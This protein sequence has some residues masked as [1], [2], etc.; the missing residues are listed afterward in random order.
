MSLRPP[1]RRFARSSGRNGPGI[2]SRLGCAAAAPSRRGVRR[3][4]YFVVL[5]SVGIVFA[6]A[7]RSRA[8]LR[9]AAAAMMPIQTA[10]VAAEDPVIQKRTADVAAEDP[11]IQKGRSQCFTMLFASHQRQPQSHTPT[12]NHAPQF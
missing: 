11:V 10:A 8:P 7:R 4:F 5:F 6:Y 1:A 3:L 2:S 12:N 9:G